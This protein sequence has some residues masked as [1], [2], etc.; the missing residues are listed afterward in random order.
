[1]IKQKE[2]LDAFI[3]R[4][5]LFR[6]NK[7]VIYYIYELHMPAIAGSGGSGKSQDRTRL[8]QFG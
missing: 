7:S 3:S 4:N 8:R 2:N 5:V 1:M 6:E